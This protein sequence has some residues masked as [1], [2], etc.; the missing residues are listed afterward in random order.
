[1]EVVVII[2]IVVLVVIEVAVVVIDFFSRVLSFEWINRILSYIFFFYRYIFV[3]KNNNLLWCPLSV[4][5]W[6]C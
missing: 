2:V 4:I 1:M 5:I 3:S 6:H